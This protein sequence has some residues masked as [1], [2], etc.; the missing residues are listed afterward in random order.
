MNILSPILELING[1]K[2]VCVNFILGVSLCGKVI[3]SIFEVIFEYASLLVHGLGVVFEDF[4]HFT[5]EQ[6]FLLGKLKT[7]IDNIFHGILKLIGDLGN[8]IIEFLF[9]GKVQT[10][11]I[12]STMEQG[13]INFF[14]LLSK[15]LIWISETL[16]ELVLFFP[17]TAYKLLL[18]AG[19]IVHYSSV[20]FTEFAVHIV[21]TVLRDIVS[22]SLAMIA[23]FLFL[24]FRRQIIRFGIGL[25][26]KSFRMV[27][28][29]YSAFYM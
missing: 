26:Y 27:S 2:I 13:I 16:V 28:L 6:V 18:K 9:H 22:Y 7:L 12:I 24:K 19:E 25:L 1:I 21:K 3:I 15:A 20:K 4:Q 5:L 10:K 14:S 11:A 8:G 29:R 17:R 23:I